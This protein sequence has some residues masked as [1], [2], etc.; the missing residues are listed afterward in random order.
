MKVDHADRDLGGSTHQLRYGAVFEDI[1]YDRFIDRTGPTFTLPN[2][3][4]TK[5]G[6]EVWIRAAP[7]LP[8]GRLYRVRRANTSNVRATTQRYF[9]FFTQD[10]WQIDDLTIRSGDSL[11]AAD[12]QGRRRPASVPGGRDTPRPR[13]RRR[14]PDPVLVT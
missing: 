8:G 13:R 3:I 4:E 10:T 2:G 5:T 7:E 6:A 12:A 9:S 1:D 14:H 11:R